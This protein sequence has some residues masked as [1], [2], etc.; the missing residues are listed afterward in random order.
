VTSPCIDR[1]SPA[2]PVGAEPLPNGN[3]INMGVYGG[4]RQASK[5]GGVGS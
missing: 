5:S 2:L 4:T 3:K 1:G